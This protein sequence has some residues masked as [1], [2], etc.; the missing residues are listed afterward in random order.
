VYPARK[1][2]PKKN[3]PNARKRRIIILGR[4]AV[5]GRT[6]ELLLQSDEYEA[7]FLPESALADPQAL[8]GSDLLLLTPEPVSERRRALLESI[9]ANPEASGIPILELRA[10]APAS[11]AESGRYTMPWPCDVEELRHRIRRLH[12][13]EERD[14][15]EGDGS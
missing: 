8:E 12:S 14:E 7:E 13:L 6:L 15:S 1:P 11:R 10:D 4:D 2:E 9:A 3:N 5:V